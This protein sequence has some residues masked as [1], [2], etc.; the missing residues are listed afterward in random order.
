MLVLPGSIYED[1]QLDFSRSSTH[2][3]LFRIQ[4]LSRNH[5]EMVFE[6]M[7]H[8][9]NYFNCLQISPSPGYLQCMVSSGRWFF[10][11]TGCSNVWCC[12]HPRPLTIDVE[13]HGKRLVPLWDIPAVTPKIYLYCFP[14]MLGN[15]INHPHGWF[16]APIKMVM[17]W[18]WFDSG[19]VYCFTKNILVV[20][21]GFFQFLFSLKRHQAEPTICSAKLIGSRKFS[22]GQHAWEECEGGMQIKS[23]W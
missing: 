21:V 2:R 16:I 11:T 6:L 9:F 7:G 10:R 17:T 8:P 18:G 22:N 19:M 4:D 14:V 1:P 12:L 15:V 3:P 13:N 5:L 20:F 23:D